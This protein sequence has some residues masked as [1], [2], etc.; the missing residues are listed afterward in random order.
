MKTERLRLRTLNQED[1]KTLYELIFSDKDV[2]KY[3]FGKDTIAE[4][5]VYEYVK[6][7]G[8][9]VLENN[10]THEIIGLAGVLPCSYLQEDDYEFGFILAKKFWGQGYASEIGKAQIESIKNALLKNRA[11]AT[12]YPENVAS[13]KCIEKLGLKYEKTILTDRGERLVYLLNFK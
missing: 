6:Q 9:K 2:I 8:L 13:I 7:I 3:T 12:V 11:V 5:N 4:Q 10:T 1:S